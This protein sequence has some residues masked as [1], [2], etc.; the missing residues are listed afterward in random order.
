MSR[1]QEA[2]TIVKSFSFGLFG[3]GIM[4]ASSLDSAKAQGATADSALVARGRYLAGAADCM[5]CHTVSKDKPYAGGL[6]INTPF[7]AIYSPNVTPD[8]DTGIGKW[9]FED[10]KNAVH[11]GIRADGTYLYPAMPFDAFTKISDDDLLALWAYFRTLPA[12]KQQNRDNELSFPFNVRDG[13]LLWRWMFFAAGSFAPDAAKGPKWN[14][15]AYLVEALGHCGTCHTPRNVMGATVEARRFEGSQIDQWYAP[16]IS[17]AALKTVNKWDKAQLVAFLKKGATNNSTALGPMQEVVHDSLTSLTDDD[18]DAMAMYLLDAPVARH[19]DS[20]HMAGRAPVAVAR[21]ARLYADNCATCHQGDGKGTAGAIPPLVGN[22]AVVGTEPFNVIAAV[23]E[24]IPA[25]GNMVAMPGFAGML[26]DQDIA[27][28]TNYVRASWGNN[29]AVKATPGLVATWRGPLSLPLYAS[30]SAREFEC[31]MVGPG[32][33]PGFDRKLIT[34]LGDEMSQRAVAYARIV[35]LYK[36][37]H[38]KASSD[39]IIN[40]TIAAYCPVIAGNETSAQAKSLALKQ[41]ALSLSSY[42]ANQDVA[43]AGPEVGIIW[44]TPLG[45]SLV[46]RLPA[47]Q[48]TLSCPADDNALVPQSL[49][50]AARQ[51]VGKPD[52]NVSANDAISQADSMAAQNPT[53]RPADVANALILAYC[54]GGMG[55]SGVKAADGQAALERYGAQVIEELQ[56]K[57]ETQARTTASR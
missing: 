41:L 6:K 34:A 31:P 50:A 11:A 5:P 37:R 19:P 12:A 23:L 15:G 10:F 2:K 20:S 57:A 53:A 14:R 27:D 30:D 24:G 39:E 52:P 33:D 1:F 51:V 7:G 18:L 22:P 40:N 36:A 35:E 43:E 47:W 8:L 4:M 38:P 17:A 21:A 44:A 3:I 32:G 9:S 46:E 25:R 49:V 56:R 13:M 16:D 45:Y 55:A 28:I 26:T 48:P 42:L 54:Q 29:A